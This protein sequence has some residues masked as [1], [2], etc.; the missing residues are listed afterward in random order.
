VATVTPEHGTVVDAQFNVVFVV[1]AT[2]GSVHG[3]SR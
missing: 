1:L 3:S 2:D